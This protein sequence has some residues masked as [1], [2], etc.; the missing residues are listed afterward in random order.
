MSAVSRLDDPAS[1]AAAPMTMIGLSSRL[2][3]W[4]ERLKSGRSMLFEEFDRGAP[5]ATLVLGRKKKKKK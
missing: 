5:I 1:E 4:K 3:D 2:L